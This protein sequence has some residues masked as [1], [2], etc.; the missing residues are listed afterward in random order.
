MRDSARNDL[1]RRRRVDAFSVEFYAAGGD[2]A[3]A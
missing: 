2:A 1:V 3:Q